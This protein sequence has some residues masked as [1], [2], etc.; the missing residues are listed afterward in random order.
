M[1]LGYVIEDGVVC[2]QQYL[3]K[4]TRNDWVIYC[5]WTLFASCAVL[6]I[7]PLTGFSIFVQVPLV[8]LF[9]FVM[10]YFTNKIIDFAK[11]PK[12]KRLALAQEQE[13]KNQ[14]NEAYTKLMETSRRRIHC[15]N[16]D[17]IYNG[18]LKQTGCPEC[19]STLAMFQ[20]DWTAQVSGKTPKKKEITHQKV[21][22]KVEKITSNPESEKII[23]NS[24]SWINWNKLPPKFKEDHLKKHIE[25]CFET[26]RENPLGEFFGS[27]FGKNN[28]LCD[29]WIKPPYYADSE[30]G[31]DFTVI[32]K[33][34]EKISFHSDTFK[35]G[36]K[37]ARY[38]CNNFTEEY[39]KSKS[40]DY[41]IEPVYTKEQ[42][43]TEKDY[44]RYYGYEEDEDE[45][46][47]YITTLNILEDSYKISS[48]KQERGVQIIVKGN[49]GYSN[50]FYAPTVEDGIEICN[51]LFR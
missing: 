47:D 35:S 42:N 19:R 43:E 31:Y 45:R 41:K 16:C 1:A 9:G 40:I 29:Y 27:N 28:N 33:K 21:K 51:N 26:S 8:T 44:D 48:I 38:L 4:K 22:N 7:P 20:T 37:K 23:S 2:F 30:N 12:Q 17:H 49:K 10:K 15:L 36:D 13:K 39:I 14:E 3:Q 5:L 50:K 32:N 18:P 6:L 25:Q 24:E 46:E 11:I 34:K